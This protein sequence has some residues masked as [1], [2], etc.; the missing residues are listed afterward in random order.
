MLTNASFD[1]ELATE[2]YLAL[3][4]AVLQESPEAANT[5]SRLV[6]Q[7]VEAKAYSAEQVWAIVWPLPFFSA[8][9]VEIASRRIA[10]ATGG[11]W[12]SSYKPFVGAADDEGHTWHVRREGDRYVATGYSAAAFCTA[13]DEFAAMALKTNPFVLQRLSRLANVFNEV[14][15]SNP[16][17]PFL[18][19]ISRAKVGSE[20]H[21]NDVHHQLS[22]AIG[23][24]TAS[25][26]MTDLGF[27]SVKPD[28]WLTRLAVH[29]GWV[30]GLSAQEIQ[31]NRSNSWQLLFARLGAIAAKAAER[32]PSINPLRE[33]D[34]YI[35]NYGM[36][37]RPGD[38]EK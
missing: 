27:V 37:F 23:P 11:G 24:I 26:A 7:S 14:A 10:N 5:C 35:A 17:I 16:E 8:M 3:R 33:A 28:I 21:F 31:R 20:A 25:H 6:Q 19:A 32:H 38:V 34:F 4:D 36:L 30:T 15:V 22:T 18:S 1:L 9:K 12:F 2:Q 13:T 29:Y